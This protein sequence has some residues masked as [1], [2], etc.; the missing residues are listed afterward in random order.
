MNVVTRRGRIS[1]W[2]V[3]VPVD[4]DAA[5]TYFTLR[6]QPARIPGHANCD[7]STQAKMC[8]LLQSPDQ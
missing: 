2:V 7:G 3:D 4:S 5:G 8:V 6:P 1:P